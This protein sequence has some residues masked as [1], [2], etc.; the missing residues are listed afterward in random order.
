MPVILS[1]P[2]AV[3]EGVTRRQVLTRGMALGLGIPLAGGLLEACSSSA[4]TAGAGSNGGGIVVGLDT[5]IDNLDPISLRSDAAYDAVVQVY[6]MPVDDRV[7]PV[8]GIL[9]G[10][11]GSLV[12]EV[13]SQ[14]LISADSAVYRFT[15]RPDVT[16]SNGDPVTADTLRYS[17]LRALEGPGYP[18]QLSGLAYGK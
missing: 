3:R 16:F 6:E 15:V 14:Y 9:E 1:R 13:A 7:Q 17:Y 12:P 5:D 10:V 2:V 8:N 4:A 18:S 11:S